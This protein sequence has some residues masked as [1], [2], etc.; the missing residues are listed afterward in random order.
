M[1]LRTCPS[2]HVAVNDPNNPTNAEVTN[3]VPNG[4]MF[5]RTCPS[6]HVAV[7]CGREENWKGRARGVPVPGARGVPVAIQQS[8]H[9][10]MMA[11]A[12]VTS[13]VP[14]GTGNKTVFTN[15]ICV[16]QV[17][18]GWLHRFPKGGSNFQGL[19]SLLRFNL[20][21][22]KIYTVIL[23]SKLLFP[24][25]KESREVSPF[26]L[27]RRLSPFFFLHKNNTQWSS[28]PTR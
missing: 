13:E 15:C 11:S 18:M 14:N 20:R 10:T 22:F 8:F 17:T 21:F 7:N 5:L 3:E 1:F 25:S 27:L 12:E 16:N 2:L 26:S 28:F 24:A 23:F 19:Y 4:G 9:E 6:L